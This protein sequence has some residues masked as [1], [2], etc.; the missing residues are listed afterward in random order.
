MLFF[1][2]YTDVEWGEI[3]QNT[4]ILGKGGIDIVHM[5]YLVNGNKIIA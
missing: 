1:F 3:P 2:L 5:A 4:D